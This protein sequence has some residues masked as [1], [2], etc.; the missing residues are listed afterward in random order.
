MPVTERWAY[1]DHSAVAPLSDPARK[2]LT[3]WANEA[4]LEGD[5]KWLEWDARVQESRRLASQLIN[6]DT[7][8]IA[9]VRSTT[10]GINFVAEGLDWNEGDNVVVPADEFP[11]NLYP[12]MQQAYR[13]VETRMVPTDNGRLDPDVL[14]QAC[15]ERTRVVSVSWVGY[16]SGYRQNLN[17]IAEIAHSKG[18]L[19]FLDA[20]Q[21]LGVYPLDVTQTP[22]DFLAADGHKWMLGPEGAGVAYIRQ[23]HLE[24]LRPFGV[25][26]NS[27]VGAANFGE[28]KLNYKKNAGR[29]EGGTTN[30]V[31]QL[32]FG[33]S[34]G[35]LMQQPTADIQTAV[36]NITDYLCERLTEIEATIIS[37]REREPCGH[38]PR[39][40]IVS[41]D[42]PG[43]DPAEARRR[44][45]DAGVVTSVRG[46][47]L[48]MAPHAYTSYEEVDRLID[49]LKQG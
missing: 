26:W 18:A 9:L 23:E 1:F 27:V 35:L 37:Q 17:T 49:V 25:G 47:H 42:L 30:M 39:S 20:I 3:D 40:G 36:L 14:R 6:A 8:E 2:V 12:W 41:A 11:S 38:D 34:L 29:Y 48:R 16:A 32:A 19:F 28:V 7:K 22:I 21:G 33:A 44:L 13:G 46:G 4:A 10:E 31:G 15:D 5:T 45:L 43:V 24:R